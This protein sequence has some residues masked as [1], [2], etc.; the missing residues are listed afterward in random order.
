M[1][2]II[3]NMGE[4]IKEIHGKYKKESKLL[5]MELIMSDKRNTLDEIPNR[6]DT[7]EEKR[8]E[9]KYLAIENIQKCREN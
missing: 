8:H 5:E 1:T 6:S 9:L 7:T 4:S 2:S 3:R